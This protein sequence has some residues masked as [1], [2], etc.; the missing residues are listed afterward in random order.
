MKKSFLFLI[1]F[2]VF[3][4]KINA[5]S[6][7]IYSRKSQ[8]YLN[9]GYNRANFADSD[10]HFK[11]K[12]YDFTLNNVVA[13]NRPTNY[14]FKDYL[15]LSNLTIPQYNFKIGYYFKDNWSI[16]IGTDHM[17][18]VMINDQTATISGNISAKVSEPEIVVNPDY[19]GTYNNTPFKINSKDFLVFE[20]T[21]GFNYAHFELEHFQNLFKIRNKAMGIDWS[22]GL[23]AGLIVPRTDAHLFG[24]GGNHYWN[25]AGYG[26]SAKTG[27]RFDLTN[28]FYINTDLKGGFTSLSKIIT[29]GNDSD[30]AQQKVWFL[31]RYFALGYQIGRRR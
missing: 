2:G 27:L 21:D 17:K 13:H 1:F 23:G 29:T 20:H 19:V 30:F 5:Q 22:Y 15:N 12:G 25:I 28:R 11:G 26:V 4:V 16:S 3:G 18:Y 24:I 9:W 7:K 31:E 14:H 8:F 10:I 6:D